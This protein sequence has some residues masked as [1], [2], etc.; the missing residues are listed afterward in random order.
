MMATVDHRTD[1][2][3]EYE[4]PVMLEDFRTG[5]LYNGTIYNYSDCG[6]YIETDYAPRPRRKIRITITGLP[7]VSSAQV[8]LAEV[9][10]RTC[11]R[12]D[13]SPYSFGMGIRYC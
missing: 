11:L 4:A 12:E 9:R 6:L 1:L 5:F 10:W 3:I 2:R 8:H 7:N 13:C